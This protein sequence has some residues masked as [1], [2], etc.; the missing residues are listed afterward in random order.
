MDVFLAAEEFQCPCCGLRLDS[1]DEIEAGGLD[2]EHTEVVTRQRE[3]E[4]DYGND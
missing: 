3:Y 2:V 4:P 1:R